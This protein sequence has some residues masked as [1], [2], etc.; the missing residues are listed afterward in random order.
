MYKKE[1]KKEIFLFQIP[2]G[3]F[4]SNGA[5]QGRAMQQQPPQPPVPPLSSSMPSLRAQVPQYLS[6]QVHEHTCTQKIRPLSHAFYYIN[7]SKH[8]RLV[9]SSM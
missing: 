2:S 8:F 6:P 5:A 1:R 3:M 9:H 4:G 7:L